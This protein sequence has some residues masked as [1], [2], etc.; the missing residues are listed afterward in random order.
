MLTHL[1]GLFAAAAASIAAAQIHPPQLSEVRLDSLEPNKDAE[2]VELMGVPGT[3]LDGYSIVVIGDGD[4][5]IGPLALDSGVIEAVV[6]LDGYAIADDRC[7]LIHSSGLLWM[8]PDVVADLRLEDV[9]NITVLL[10]EHAKCWQGQDLDTDDDGALDLT[11]WAAVVD[12]VAIACGAPGTVSEWTYAPTFGPDNGFAVFQVARCLDTGEWRMG[13]VHLE[14]GVTDTP[15]W[16]NQ[17]CS[18]AVCAG[19][20]DADAVVGAQD[21]AYLLANWDALGTAAD[22]N[23]DGF[24]GSADIAILLSHWGECEL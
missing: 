7:L 8:T 20:F 4:D 1:A 16:P 23:A 17:Q 18:G 12:G 14:M 22:L 13:G 19:D 2:F 15:G 9:D 5:D 11:P 24:V 3:P 10:V 21:L 6:P